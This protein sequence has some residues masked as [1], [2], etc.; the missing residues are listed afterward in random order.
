MWE[1]MFASCVGD[2]VLEISRQDCEGSSPDQE[3]SITS[4]EVAMLNSDRC[5]MELAT[6]TINHTKKSYPKSPRRTSPVWTAAFIVASSIYG[7]LLVV[8]C[9]TFFTAEIQISAI[10]MHYFEGFYLYLYSV[11]LLFLFYV[12]FYLLH[13]VPKTDQNRNQEPNSKKKERITETDKSHGSIF[14]RIGAVAFGLGTMIYNGLE[15]GSYFEIPHSSPCYSLLLAVNPFLQAAFTF[16]QMYFIFTYSRLSI[17]K[18]K[19]VARLGL[20][21]LVGTNICVWIRTLGKETLQ[22]LNSGRPPAIM[23]ELFS[24]IRMSV[25][26]N[27]STS[28]GE[29]A[30]GAPLTSANLTPISPVK[31]NLSNPCQREHIMGSIL[32]DTSPYLYP[33]IVEY[34]L[35]GAAFLYV[36]W[37]SIGRTSR[38]MDGSPSLPSSPS[39]GIVLDNL[40]TSSRDSSTVTSPSLYSCLGS[41]KGLF[42]GFLFLVAS[43]TSLIIFFVLVHHETY[44]LLATLISD[45]THSTLLILSCFAIIIAYSKVC[46]LRFQPGIP[47]TAD[48]GLRDLLL[49]VAAFGLYVYSFFGVIAGAMNLNSIQHFAVLIT[50]ALTIIQVTL[51]S[52]FI[53]DVVCRKRSSHKQPGRQLITFLMIANFTLWVIYTFEMQKV[54]ASPVQ[55]KVYGFTAWALI[56]R[57][58]LPL[59]IFYRIHSTITFAEVWKNSYK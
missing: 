10:P 46:K 33:F 25:T 22:E 3:T 35:I 12:L 26:V 4:T 55:L 40:S 49:R 32:A 28:N 18:F 21:H 44:K 15:F 36:M 5:E 39:T 23:E 42:C 6:K 50:S 54:E 29:Y 58:T 47:D 53:A 9:L 37:S 20:M 31:I 16:A 56:I 1:K 14:L 43:I 2:T 8:L 7:Q 27:R 52:L 34:S 30:L 48:G 11:S 45:I 17:N 38:S 51:Q 24:P 41:S 57:I 19:L 59:S 13:D